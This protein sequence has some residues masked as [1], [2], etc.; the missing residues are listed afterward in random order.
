MMKYGS[1]KAE[2]EAAQKY[3]MT[4]IEV[5]VHLFLPVH[6]AEMVMKTRMPGD[7]AAA[8]CIRTGRRPAKLNVIVEMNGDEKINVSVTEG[9]VQP[10]KGYTIVSQEVN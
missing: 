5:E 8:Y 3:D 4:G 1:D 6:T 10:R 9:E 7:A 2:L